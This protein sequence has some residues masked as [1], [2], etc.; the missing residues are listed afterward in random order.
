M[1]KMLVVAGLVALTMIISMSAFAQEGEGGIQE[2]P[3]APSLETPSPPVLP[4]VTGIYLAQGVST[5]GEPYEQSLE[6]S[7]YGK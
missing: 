3:E 5:S 2:A 4:E 7:H 1:R 6:I